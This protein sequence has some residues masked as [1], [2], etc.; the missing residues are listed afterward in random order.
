MKSIKENQK[1]KRGRP[2]TGRD[3][4]VT[5]RIPEKAIKMLDKWAKSEGI[6]RGEAM[7]RLIEA[8]L[9]GRDKNR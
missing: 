7:R 8:G 1:R 2:A 9:Q 3:P 6:S 4:A 5:T